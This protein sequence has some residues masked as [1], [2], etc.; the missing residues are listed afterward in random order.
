VSGTFGEVEIL[1]AEHRKAPFPNLKDPDLFGD[2]VMPD[3][4]IAGIVDSYVKQQGVISPRQRSLLGSIVHE[5]RA[6]GRRI[7]TVEGRAYSDRLLRM[8]DLV[9]E[10][11]APDGHGR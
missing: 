2:L 8:A 4:D 9:L 7:R 1:W 11:T 5:V 3:A 6:I 10:S